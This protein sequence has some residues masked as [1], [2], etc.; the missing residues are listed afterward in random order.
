M[1]PVPSEDT[2]SP[3]A[4]LRNQILTGLLASDYSILEPDLELVSFGVRDAL[5]VAGKPIDYVYFPENGMVSVVA[6]GGPDWQIEAGVIG[7][8]GM[9][10]FSLVLGDDHSPYATFVQIVSH[11]TRIRTETLRRALD[12]SDSLR[13]SL[14]RFAA[15]FMVQ[16]AHTALA[17]GRAKLDQRLARWLLMAHDRAE[18]DK[19][20]L[21]HELLALMLGVRRAG[22]T[23][24]LREL[25]NRSLIGKNRGHI[26]ML[27]RAGL[28]RHA[29]GFYGGPEAELLR[30]TG[31]KPGDT[32]R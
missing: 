26:M 5:E 15:A 10:G 18:D 25:E 6:V 7:R 29:A 2:A 28:E 27:D 4:L 20:A 19:L 13:Q 8:E 22:V 31:W 16:I 3:M 17:N 30:L 9:T 11:G 24:A 23:T 32:R 21:T 14:L 1:R 12:R